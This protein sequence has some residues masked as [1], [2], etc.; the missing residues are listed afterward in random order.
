MEELWGNCLC[1]PCYCHIPHVLPHIHFKFQIQ[2]LNSDHILLQT[3]RGEETLASVKIVYRLSVTLKKI[4]DLDP[5][6]F[7]L[8]CFTHWIRKSHVKLQSLS[9]WWLCKRCA[10]Q[11]DEG[12]LPYSSPAVTQ[13]CSTATTNHRRVKQ[14]TFCRGIFFHRY[15]SPTGEWECTAFYQLQ[16]QLL[17][18]GGAPIY[19][20]IF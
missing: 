14:H 18:A 10:Q 3:Y 6:K 1:R 17:R 12:K 19:R 8:Y 7:P 2:P 9:S 11:Q 20:G 15:P 16:K 4:I 13:S 5:H